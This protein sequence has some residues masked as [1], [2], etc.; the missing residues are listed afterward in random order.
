MPSPN[1]NCLFI[2]KHP[3]L[4]ELFA[5]KQKEEFVD[6]YLTT[7]SGEY[8]AVHRCVVTAMSL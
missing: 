5:L 3:L 4:N 8:C 7:D 6:L 1:I 2:A